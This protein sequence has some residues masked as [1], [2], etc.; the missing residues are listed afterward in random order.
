MNEVG[1]RITAANGEQ[2]ATSFLKQWLSMVVQR[3]N[4]AAILGTFA[5]SDP[6]SK[7]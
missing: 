1:R 7:D 3:G 6:S 4:A 2:R 5:A